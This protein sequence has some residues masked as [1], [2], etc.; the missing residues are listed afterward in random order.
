MWGPTTL[1]EAKKPLLFSSSGTDDYFFRFRGLFLAHRKLAMLCF[2]AF[3]ASHSRLSQIP[4]NTFGCGRPKCILH[5]LPRPRRPSLNFFPTRKYTPNRKTLASPCVGNSTGGALYRMRM[6]GG[7]HI[8]ELTVRGVLLT[9]EILLICN[10]APRFAAELAKCSS[11]AGSGSR[12]TTVRWIF[13]GGSQVLKLV[14]HA[15]L[16]HDG[17][18]NTVPPTSDPHSG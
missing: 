10:A 12:S 16:S 5:E 6:V 3:L 2:C 13:R 4:G 1:A 7:A 14:L 9:T 8:S 18:H 11:C 17:P 15:T